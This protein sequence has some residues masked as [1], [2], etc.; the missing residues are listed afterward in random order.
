MAK[1]VI[2]I[3]NAPNDGTGDGLRNAFTKVNSNFTELYDAQITNLNSL[4]DVTINAATSGQALTYNGTSWTNASILWNDI[5]NKP[6]FSLVATTGSYNDLNNKPT[7]PT[8][9]SNLTDTTGLLG[10]NTG[11]ITFSGVQII[12]SGTASGDGNE[13]STLE[14]VPDSSLTGNHQYLIIDPTAP[15]HI[16]I[17][18][19]GTQDQSN[20]D[21]FLGGEKNHVRIRDNQGVRI[22][23]LQT[24]DNYWYYSDITHFTS[25]SWFTESGNHF[26]EF[27]TTN[28]EMISKFWDFS[29]GGLNRV[30]LN[31]GAEIQYGGTASN[32]VGNTYRVQVLTAPPASPTALTNIDFHIFVDNINS[33]QLEN[34]DFRVDVLDDIRMFG[35]DIF[36]F[37]NYSIEEPIEITTDYDNNS[38]T[39]RFQPNGT[40]QFPD[41]GNLRIST[42]V[43]SSSIGAIGNKAG[44]VV[45][46]TAYIYYCTADYDGTTNIWKRVAW[47]NETW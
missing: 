42:A 28:A 39:W 16:H 46:D 1:Q 20:A 37:V 22:Q 40:L 41:G 36:R 29:N 13:Y 47:A 30:L 12:G 14:L 26:V 9:V 32:T 10:S 2:N 6:N 33:I 27:T 17:R 19:G 3:G 8:D 35:R 18:A 24:T 11:D 38:W 5:I 44:T 43:P 21:L 45:F 34:N 7:I 4:T 15:S 23:N 25:G 31:G